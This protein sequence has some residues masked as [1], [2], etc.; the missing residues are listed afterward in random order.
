M[1]KIQYRSEHNYIILTEPD[2]SL[3][4]IIFWLITA[5]SYLVISTIYI[6]TVI[7]ASAF[8]AQQLHVLDTVPECITCY[9]SIFTVQF[10]Y[11]MFFV[12]SEVP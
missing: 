6:A 1:K 7:L 9:Y 5:F 12:Q 2:D 10:Y 11:D 4:F 8:Q 3:R